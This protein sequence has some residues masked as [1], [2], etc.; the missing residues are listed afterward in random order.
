MQAF[1]VCIEAS[2]SSKGILLAMEL[3]RPLG[4]VVQKSTCS[5][6]GDPEMPDWSSIANDV[7]VNEKH[8]LGS[9]YDCPTLTTSSPRH[10]KNW[11][12]LS[13]CSQF[14]CKMLQVRSLQPCAAGVAAASCEAT[15]RAHGHCSVSYNRREG[16]HRQGQGKGVAESAFRDE[17]LTKVGLSA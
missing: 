12:P 10:L 15:C 9:R 8:L 7:V 14:F 11:C 4:T 6:V 17:L 13:L 16:S 3:T 5:A 1:D 2:G